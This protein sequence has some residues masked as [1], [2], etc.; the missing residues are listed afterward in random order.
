MYTRQELPINMEKIKQLSI[1]KSSSFDEDQLITDKLFAAIVLKKFK[2]ARILAEGG[3][4]VKARLSSGITPLMAACDAVA[5]DRHLEKK[6]ELIKCLLKT[7]AEVNATDKYRR[8]SL[9]YAC[10]SGCYKV[11]KLLEENGADT[12][13]IDINGKTPRFYAENNFTHQQF[14]VKTR[15]DSIAMGSMM[16]VNHSYRLWDSREFLDSLDS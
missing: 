15:R 12:K 2:L 3:V 5:D 11:M 16:N 4:N 7:G 8:T 10:I 14:P 13:F 9:H 6:I 1:E